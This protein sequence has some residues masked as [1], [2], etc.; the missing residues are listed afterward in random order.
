MSYSI[1]EFSKITDL[2]IDTIRYYE[3]KGLI[4]PNRDKNNRRVFEESDIGWLEF[5]KKLKLTGMKL[6]NIKYYSQL[7]YQG[8]KTIEIRLELLYQQADVLFVKQK[9]VAE[10]IKFLYNKINI[11]NNMLEE[12]R[13][14]DA[15]KNKL[16]SV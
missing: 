13:K 2:A 16:Q 11:Y 8:D 12:K 6:K 1:G 3:K 9:E 7:R 10:H 4:I 5:I 15:E 14:T